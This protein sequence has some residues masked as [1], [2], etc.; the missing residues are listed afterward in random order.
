MPSIREYYFKKIKQIEES[1][2][3]SK[4]QF[5]HLICKYAGLKD[6]NEFIFHFDDEFKYEEDTD[7]TINRV[8]NGEMLEYITNEAYFCGNYLYV[9]EN[10]LIPR[11][12][13][14]ELVDYFSKYFK[15]MGFD[16]GTSTVADICTGSGCIA[17]SLVE[18]CSLKIV[19]ASDISEGALEVAKKN[20][21]TLNANVTFL[22]GNITDPF[23]EQG[24]K[25][26]CIVCNPPYIKDSSTIDGRTWRFEPHLALISD[27]DTYFY[28]YV[29]K[30]AD[31]L[32]NK[33]HL[34]AF[35]IGEDMKDSLEV[36]AR[37]YL[38][39]DRLD[40]IKDMDGK[41]RF[42][43]ISSDTEVV[44]KAA[45]ALK[46][47]GVIAFPT[48]TV[49]GLGVA[50]DDKE[51][52][53]RL[54]KIKGRPEN[55]PYSL[56]L[57]NR[58]EISKYAHISLDE[59]KI[60]DKFL[61]GPLTILLKKKD[62]PEWVTLGSEYVGIRVPDLETITEVINEFGKPILAPSANRSGEKPALTS[63]E[64]HEVF[65]NELDVVIEGNASNDMASTI[66]KIDDGVHVIRQGKITKEE[67]EEALK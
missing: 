67:I 8:L 47:H 63:Q 40:F 46:N 31:K 56:M 21:F 14:E 61:P 7:S 59:Q 15:A 26:D 50:Y 10:V 12:E 35:E 48:E 28:E 57:G 1:D 51:A 42:M 52:F 54:N 23:I 37:K 44:S 17:V 2:R 39:E 62:L 29:L 3:I 5:V 19:F 13:T 20:T 30:T 34:L 32:L 53:E 16:P 66:I 22:K 45:D 18:K 41:W 43:I 33:K 9:N 60:I 38:P 27:P 11:Q 4:P 25:F 36:I 64:V 55:K 24:L 58:A 49:M 65:G 6:E